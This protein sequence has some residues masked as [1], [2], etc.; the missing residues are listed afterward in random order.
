[1]RALEAAQD[2][3]AVAQAEYDAAQGAQAATDE[4]LKSLQADIERARIGLE[5]QEDGVDPLLALELEKAQRALADL[6]DAG[7]DPFLELAVNQAQADLQAANLLAPWDGVTQEIR[8]RPGETVGAGTGLMVL[9]DPSAVEARTT[10]IEED[11]PLVQ[12]GQAAELFFDA[13][14]EAAVQGRVARIVPR[15]VAGESRPLYYVYIA[16]EDPPKDLLPGMTVDA[17]IIIAQ[18]TDVLRLPRALVRAGKVEVWSGG[19]VQKRQ[20]QT[21][22]RG[23]VYVEILDGLQEGELVVGQ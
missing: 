9:I 14:P 16:L 22:L 2:A 4:Q 12:V 20:V 6:Q 5:R 7:V 17:S 15:R 18:R 21:G 11:L 13:A 23:D 19:Q 3:R 10:V 1:L 8:A